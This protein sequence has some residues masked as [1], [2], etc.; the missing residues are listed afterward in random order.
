LTLRVEPER[1]R[2]EILVA[3]D[4]ARAAIARG[5]GF[6]VTE[7][8]MRRRPRTSNSAVASGSSILGDRAEPRGGFAS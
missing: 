5:E 1:R 4:A 7:E 3:V 8:S 6:D 2:A